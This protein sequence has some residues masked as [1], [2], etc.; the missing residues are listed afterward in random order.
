MKIFKLHTAC[1]SFLVWDTNTYIFWGWYNILDNKS[2]P[3][4]FRKFQS[5]IVIPTTC[6]PQI[7]W[8]AQ[9]SEMTST[10]KYVQLSL[11]VKSMEVVLFWLFWIDTLE[12][13]TILCTSHFNTCQILT[14]K[15]FLLCSF[16]RILQAF[17]FPHA[18]RTFQLQVR[19]KDREQTLPNK[20]AELWPSACESQLQARW[21]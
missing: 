13:S 4:T 3:N 20:R 16:S 9:S 7:A 1:K 8:G 6:S 2:T 5:R 12:L 21:E 17:F 14:S 11:K 19:C 10:F 15:L 18:D